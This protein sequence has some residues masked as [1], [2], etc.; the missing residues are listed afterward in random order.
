VAALAVYRGQAC[1]PTLD[2]SSRSIRATSPTRHWLDV[3]VVHGA[4]DDGLHLSAEEQDFAGLDGAEE[5]EDLLHHG[6]EL[7]AIVILLFGQGTESRRTSAD[8][9]LKTSHTMPAPLSKPAWAVNRS[10][11]HTSLCG[12]RLP[13]A[14]STNLCG[15]SR[16]AHACRDGRTRC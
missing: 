8:G 10:Q 15:L 12:A 16:A 3:E 9:I 1:R 11:L 2:S 13:A 5:T 14:M 7:C 6:L 4:R